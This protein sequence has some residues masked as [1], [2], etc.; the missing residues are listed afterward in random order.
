[1]EYYYFRKQVYNFVTEKLTKEYGLGNLNF[2]MGDLLVEEI[3]GIMWENTQFGMDRNE[4]VEKAF[5]DFHDRI[6]DIRPL[7]HGYIITFSTDAN[8]CI[9]YAWHVSVFRGLVGTECADECCA[10]TF[11]EE[12][13][14]SLIYGIPGVQDGLYLD[15]VEN[16]AII[17]QYLHSMENGSTA[18]GP[19]DPSGHDEEK[20][21]LLIHEANAL[22]DLFFNIKIYDIDIQIKGNQL[23][24]EDEDGNRWIENEIFE[25]VL[26]ECLA[27]GENGKLIDGLYVNKEVLDMVRHFAA[28]RGVEIIRVT[29]SKLISADY[30][31]SS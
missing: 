24:A 31:T 30:S 18:G 5:S 17:Q 14:V 25:F 22:A 2:E 23:I 27:F 15:T 12:D 26:N 1:M 9:P 16:R 4:S 3:I 10:T 29:D 19:S 20:E 7:T 8:D 6:A 28:Q 21:Q 13:G 11:A